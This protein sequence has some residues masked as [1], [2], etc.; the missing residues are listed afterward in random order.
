MNKDKHLQTINE[1]AAHY[2]YD[3]RFMRE[4]LSSSEQGY[5]HFA[6]FLP[7]AHFRELLTL[8][9]YWLVKI[10]VMQIADCGA[11]LQLNIRMAQEQ[12]IA[13]DLITKLLKASDTLTFA[14]QQLRHY[15]RQLTMPAGVEPT[16]M[17]AM[18]ARYSR[19]QLLEF[20]LCVASA[21]VFPTIKRSIAVQQSCVIPEIEVA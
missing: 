12:G 13:A 11:C 9:D 8:E 5:Q 14:Q 10:A 3:S 21:M 2:R 15:A 17:Q 18:Q 16:L 6:D 1:F 7:L 4:L 19:G 20:G